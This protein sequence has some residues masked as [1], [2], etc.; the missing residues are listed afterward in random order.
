VRTTRRCC[1][2]GP[3]SRPKGAIR[4]VRELPNGSRYSIGMRSGG[5]P[6]GSVSEAASGEGRKLGVQP[7][8]GEDTNLT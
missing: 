3:R 7:A 4:I 2:V 6:D 8:S 5:S 1:L